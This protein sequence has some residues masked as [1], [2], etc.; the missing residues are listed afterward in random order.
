[1][2]RIMLIFL[3]CASIGLMSGCGS[4]SGTAINS[5]SNEPPS[6]AA[7]STPNP[8]APDTAS[9]AETPSSAAPSAA[10]YQKITA[11][12]AKTMMDD[13]NT[14]TLVDVRTE[15]EYKDQHI[16]GAVLIPVDVIADKVESE[17]PDKTA[18]I[19]IYC[20]SGNRSATAANTLVG[21][22]YTNVYDMGGIQSWTYG[23]VSGE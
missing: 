13:G 14:Y 12:Q 4:G 11:E 2:K 20:R 23:T 6:E 10:S 15:S 8:T 5:A 7:L 19:L 9:I 16:E 3:I 18:R 1:M 21:L 17:L 22:G